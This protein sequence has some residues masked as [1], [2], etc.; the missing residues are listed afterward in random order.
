[1]VKAKSASAKLVGQKGASKSKTDLLTQVA[2]E[3]ETL[4]KP[5]AFALC[6]DIIARAGQD[7]FRL[8][9][10]LAVIHDKSMADGGE[11]WLDGHASFAELV[12]SRFGFEY[13]KAATLISIYKNL[14]EK[15][16][17][18]ETVKDMGWAKLGMCAGILTQKNAESWAEKAKKYNAD[19]FRDIVRKA[20]AGKSGSDAQTGETTATKKLSVLLHG[21]QYPAVRKALDKGKKESKTE[22]DSVALF[23]ICQGYLGNAIELDIKEGDAADGIK[24][25]SEKEK[26][27]IFTG[28]LKDLGADTALELFDKVYGD[29]HLTAKSPEQQAEE[30]EEAKALKIKY[31]PAT[32]EADK[33]VK[34]AATQ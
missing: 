13:R 28:L 33:A 10:V 27:S 18:W 30:K 11:A 2:Q 20:K 8:G 24:N 5:K 6:D 4:T 15:Q 32:F 17:P 1:M 3:V 16:I 25:A 29:W 14:V 7:D 22:F 12:A 21:D 31:D 34:E 9:G 23:N 19:Q 26:K